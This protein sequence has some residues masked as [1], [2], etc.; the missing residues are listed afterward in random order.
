[1]S[2][3]FYT[4][5]PKRTRAGAKSWVFGHYM[6]FP[7]QREDGLWYDIF[8]FR[9]IDRTTFGAS[10]FLEP[11]R[12]NLNARDWATK[13]VL[14]ESFRRTVQTTDPRL[15]QLWKRR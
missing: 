5:K 13:V 12:P 9:N 6:E 10:E 11:N 15:I 2:G 4:I 3:I 14:D 8:L 7:S 1:M